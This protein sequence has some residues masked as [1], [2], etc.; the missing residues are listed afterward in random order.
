MSQDGELQQSGEILHRY[1]YKCFNLLWAMFLLAFER[2]FISVL[3]RGCNIN[4]QSTPD[5]LNLQGKLKKVRGV[6]SS[7]YR[8]LR[9]NDR[10]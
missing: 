6:G 3:I 1:L 4:M 8:E 5:K 10:K 7:S 2:H 9:I